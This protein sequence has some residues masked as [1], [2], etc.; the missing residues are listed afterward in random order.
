[1]VYSHAKEHLWMKDD[2]H[3]QQ[4]GKKM[5]WETDEQIKINFRVKIYLNKLKIN[6]IHS[7]S[8]FS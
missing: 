8:Y 1:M 5:G 4:K 3:K 2:N 6:I 7:I